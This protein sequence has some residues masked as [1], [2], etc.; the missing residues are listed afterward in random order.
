MHHE[1]VKHSEN[2]QS[3]DATPRLE[4]TRVPTERERFAYDS[5]LESFVQEV[6][7]ISQLLQMKIISQE[8]RTNLV[9]LLEISSFALA[10][11]VKARQG[12]WTFDSTVNLLSA[13]DEHRTKCIPRRDFMQTIRYSDV[14]TEAFDLE[15][16]VLPKHRRES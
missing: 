12:K 2:L 3:E 5:A 4:Q 15:E 14:L 1:Q 10:H 16:F 9:V 6:K 7:S 13:I 11:I 8:E